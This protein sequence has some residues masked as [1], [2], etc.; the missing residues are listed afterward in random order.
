MGN[1]KAQ[2]KENFYRITRLE[3]LVDD[4]QGRLGR[5]TLVFKGILQEAEGKEGSWLQIENFIAKL[6]I[7]HLGMDHARL[8]IERAHRSSKRQRS[9]QEPHNRPRPIFVAFQSWKI[10]AEELK[11]AKIL[12]DNPYLYEGNE[13]NIYIEQMYSPAATQEQK[14]ALH[15]RW[16]LKKANPSWMVFLRCPARL[17]YRTED[18]GEVREWKAYDEQKPPSHSVANIIKAL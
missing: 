7:E 18:D 13:V 6:L 1:V 3:Q 12:R 2:S 15:V 17:F 14:A 10:A 5:N 11:K 16:S 9:H 4:L 8:G